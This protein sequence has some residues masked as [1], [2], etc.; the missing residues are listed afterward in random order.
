M[1]ARLEEVCQPPSKVKRN[2]SSFA[3]VSLLAKKRTKMLDLL[4]RLPLKLLAARLP[5]FS[6]LEAKSS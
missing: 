3:S 1:E 2:N 6:V 5:F 4:G